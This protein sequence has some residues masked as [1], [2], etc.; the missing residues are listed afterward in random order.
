MNKGLSHK[1]ANGRISSSHCELTI[2]PTLHG[3]S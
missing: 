1:K 3:P 2:L